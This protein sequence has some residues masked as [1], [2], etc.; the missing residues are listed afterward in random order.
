MVSIPSGNMQQGYPCK[1][2]E[3]RE[4]SHAKKTNNKTERG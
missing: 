1:M 4:T 3:F 2:G